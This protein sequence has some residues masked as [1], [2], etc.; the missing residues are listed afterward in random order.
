MDCWMKKYVVIKGRL[1]DFSIRWF[2]PLHDTA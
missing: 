2:S 1:W